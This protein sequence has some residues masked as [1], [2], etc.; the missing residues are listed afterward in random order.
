MKINSK[1]IL[2]IVTIVAFFYLASVVYISY[3]A[4]E[5]SITDA[6]N[7][8]KKEVESFANFVK[9]E[10]NTDLGLV[11][12]L[13]E[14][15]S[16]YDDYA[17][18]SLRE[19]HNKMMK[20]VFN[21]TKNALALWVSW[22]LYAIDSTYTK[23]HGRQTLEFFREN[24]EIKNRRAYRDMD[25]PNE[26]SMYYAVKSDP[27]EIITDPYYYS[28]NAQDSVLEASVSA[29]IMHYNLFVGIVGLDVSLSRFFNL[30]KNIHPFK[31]S[32]AFLV[33]NN[34]TIIAHP[35]K[36]FV[37]KKIKDIYPKLVIDNDLE[38]KIKLGVK[39]SFK[40]TI[41]KFSGM[42]S[43]QLHPFKIGNSNIPWAVGLIIP[44]NEVVKE[45]E[46]A[47]IITLIIGIIGLIILIVIITITMNRLT[48]P[49]EQST[50]VLKKI[51]EGVINDN[52]KMK[53]KRKDEF[54]AIS[55]AVNNV[56]DM[57][58]GIIIYA[59]E[60]SRGNLKATYKTQSKND[61]LGSALKE[62]QNSLEIVKQEEE[63]RKK[64]QEI[65][66]WAS[67]GLAKIGDIV[68]QNYDNQDKMLYNA[69]SNLV[70]YMDAS[71]GGFFMLSEDQSGNKFME[72]RATFA[73]EREEEEHDIKKFPVN[74]GFIGRVYQT[75]SVITIDEIPETYLKIKSGLGSAPP[76]YLTLVPVLIKNEIIGIIE[77]SNFHKFKDYE[78]EF[79]KNI[80]QSFANSI[81]SYLNQKQNNEF[82]KMQKE[83]TLL[84]KENERKA[85]ESLKELQN[86]QRKVLQREVKI[87]SLLEAINKSVLVVYYS[88]N[89]IITDINN[90]FVNFIG[91][92]KETILGSKQ[93][94]FEMTENMNYNKK[95]L[96]K[97]ILEGKETVTI[98]QNLKIENKTF[99]LLSSYSP[100]FDEKGN[101]EQIIN[102]A[103]EIE[104]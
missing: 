80:T 9:S 102:I 89:G 26:E 92:K 96:W 23:T 91:I 79:L 42:Q 35:Q 83:Q 5:R 95:E 39:T 1:I 25:S 60:I 2:S 28:Y 78:I 71:T 19:T 50:Y 24:G 27:Q 15:F 101:V 69:L 94:D 36:E 65:R 4:R 63:L 75:K 52:L 40:S 8:A 51:G 84:L 73:Y 55:K 13:A 7:L 38:S 64:E 104:E 48:S 103:Q 47:F 46:N 41:N 17:D 88:P 21:K 70:K 56:I 85:L 31:N 14:G 66:T 18:Y 3:I 67:T 29:P 68:R 20:N 16:A 33:S 98:Q 82:L 53:V 74:E 99:K 32:I 58:T 54:G 12:G 11:R 93:G 43:I 57:L 49:V 77:I 61:I 30:I 100:I 10:L 97:K 37:G 72:L 62:M 86:Q 34:G 6:Q 59:H 81:S 44:E 76:R 87:N 22:E 90:K 45:G